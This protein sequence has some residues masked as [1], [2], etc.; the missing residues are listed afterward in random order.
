MFSIL[1]CFPWLI[2]ATFDQ[3]YLATKTYKG[4]HIDINDSFIKFYLED[5]KGFLLTN[6]LFSIF[7]SVLV[8]IS[9][10][11]LS[12]N[13]TVPQQSQVQSSNQTRDQAEEESKHHTML[14]SHHCSS[15]YLQSYP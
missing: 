14:Q 11:I 1:L 2:R 9:L 4:E 6:S 5:I 8:L 7:D 10:T 13:L 3:V 12:K 15:L